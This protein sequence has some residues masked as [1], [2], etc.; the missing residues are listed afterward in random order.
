MIEKIRKANYRNRGIIKRA[1]LG[2]AL[3]LSVFVLSPG[4]VNISGWHF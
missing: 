3:S 2:L 1:R 4:W